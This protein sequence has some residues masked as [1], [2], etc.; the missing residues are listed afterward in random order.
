MHA[1]HYA[2]ILGR[3]LEPDPIAAD[4]NPY[5]YA[6]NSAITNTDSSGLATGYRWGTCGWMRMHLNAAGSRGWA[7]LWGEAGCYS[8][9][10]LSATWTIS[11]WNF[12]RGVGGSISGSNPWILSYRW[13]SPVYYRFTGSGRV[14]ASVSTFVGSIIFGRY[15]QCVGLA[16]YAETWIF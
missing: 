16:P 6:L 8:G 14:G 12:S 1:R 10:F 9:F 7:S 13:T 11:W 15:S 2:P 5:A 4:R 3:N